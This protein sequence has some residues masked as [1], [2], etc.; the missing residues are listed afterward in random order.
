MFSGVLLEHGPV[1]T[2]TLDS[3]ALVVVDVQRGFVNEASAPVVPVIVELVRR[4]Q[5]AGGVTVLTRFINRPDSAFVRLIGW[6]A[7]MSD[8]PGIE[9]APEI[10]P[11]APTATMVVLKNGYT[12]LAPEVLRLLER[13]KR[14]NVWVAGLDTESCV[15]ATCLHAFELGL[16][17][18]LLDDACASHAGQ[19]IH[20][21]GRLVISRLIG[22]GRITTTACT[23]I[24]LDEC[25]PSPSRS[26]PSKLPPSAL[27]TPARRRSQGDHEPG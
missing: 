10:A 7:L 1:T 14:D 23:P 25:A 12:A 4:W 15:L 24:D 11:L 19:D 9:F 20:D 18:W 26:M 27:T 2:P 5:A 16:T 22:S 13:E 6:T 21:A 17:P 3:S 8:D